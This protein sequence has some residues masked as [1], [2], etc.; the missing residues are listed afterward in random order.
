MA[1]GL[2]AATPSFIYIGEAVL[3]PRRLDPAL[4]GAGAA[5]AALGAVPIFTGTRR[6]VGLLQMP[7]AVIG[8]GSIVLLDLGTG[9]AAGTGLLYFSVPVLLAAVHLRLPGVIAVTAAAL[10]GEAV[11]TLSLMPVADAA[12]DLALVGSTLLLTAAACCR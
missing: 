3:G 2:L 4:T 11:V 1:T 7:A 8:C 5:L 10:T 9:N 12:L 6:A